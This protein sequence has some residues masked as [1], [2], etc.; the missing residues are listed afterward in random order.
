MLV[1]YIRE[2]KITC[3]QPISRIF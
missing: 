3:L 2:E 1:T